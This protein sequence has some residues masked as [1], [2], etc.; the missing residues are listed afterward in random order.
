MLAVLMMT[1]T[2]SRHAQQNTA[3]AKYATTASC[4][5]THFHQTN[6]IT[7]RGAGESCRDQTPTTRPAQIHAGAVINHNHKQK[8]LQ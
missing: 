5:S 2:I 4:V 1:D 8:D 7:A 3:T 6:T